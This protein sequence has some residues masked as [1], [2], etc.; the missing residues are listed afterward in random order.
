M[1]PWT[2]EIGHRERCE[3]TPQHMK[4]ETEDWRIELKPRSAKDAGNHQELGQRQGT[5][6]PSELP[7]E[8][9]PTRLPAS[10][11]VV[12]ICYGSSRKQIH[13]PTLP[14]PCIP[15]QHWEPILFYLYIYIF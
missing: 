4:M 8:T 6:S 3:D 11:P 9:N 7:Q 13:P 2:R 5:D 1:C 12:R 10:H 15:S 14:I